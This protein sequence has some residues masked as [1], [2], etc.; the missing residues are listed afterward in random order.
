MVALAA[1]VVLLIGASGGRTPCASS[2]E[3]WA[4]DGGRRS[5]DEGNTVTR[6]PESRPALVVTMVFWW[7]TSTVVE[8]GGTYDHTAWFKRA[9][10]I[11]L[12]P[13]RGGNSSL[14]A[15]C[16]GGILNA[17]CTA[18]TTVPAGSSVD[19]MSEQWSWPRS[20][21]SEADFAE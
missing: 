10:S 9:Y 18:V 12:V 4:R 17:C 6:P 13:D 20:R 2:G 15:L 19:D 21:S 7:E 8:G 14:Q 11:A 5:S 3:R 16:V 1:I